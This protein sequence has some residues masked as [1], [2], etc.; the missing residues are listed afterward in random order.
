ME[1]LSGMAMLTGYPD[2]PPINPRGPCDAIQAMQAVIA[3]LVGL[4][5]RDRDGAGVLVEVPMVETVLAVVAESQLEHEVLG[6]ELE[7]MGNRS[8][9]AAPQGL[10]ACRGDE[11]W[12][13]VAV[14]DD[15]HWKGLQAAL[16]WEDEPELSTATG[17][18]VAHDQLDRRIAAWASGQ[19]RDAAVAHLLAHGVPAAP[20]VDGRYLH[21]DQQLAARR[22]FED[23]EHPFV[24]RYGTPGLPFRLASVE[25]WFDRAAPTLGQHNDEVLGGLL[26]VG[27]SERTR[28]RADGVIGEQVTRKLG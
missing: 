22:F 3:A 7:R 8:P 12:L 1:Q 10:Y 26:G 6:L 19:E 9:F 15:G 24:G 25:R 18:R 11:R 17:R 23:V 2:G 14:E 27:E 13:A 4:E 28:L 21:F 20:A 16:G 5:A